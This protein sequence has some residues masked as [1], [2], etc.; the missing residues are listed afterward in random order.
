M[1]ALSEATG[2]HATTPVSVLSSSATNQR[3]LRRISQHFIIQLWLGS[4]Q[5]ASVKM[6]PVSPLTPLYP[7]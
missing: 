7:L 3:A 5:Y 1:K 4:G 6:T 2:L